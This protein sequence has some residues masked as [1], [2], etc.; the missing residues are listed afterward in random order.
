MTLGLMLLVMAILVL[1]TAWYVL[2]SGRGPDG[3]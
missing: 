1:T 3:G 2:R